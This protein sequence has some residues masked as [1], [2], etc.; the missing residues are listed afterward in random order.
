ME[1]PLTHLAACACVALALA[2]PSPARAAIYRYDPTQFPN[3]LP[4]QSPTPGTSPWT[5][6]ASPNPGQ[7]FRTISGNVLTIYNNFNPDSLR[8]YYYYNQDPTATGALGAALSSTTTYEMRTRVRILTPY[9]GSG[10]GSLPLYEPSIFDG[11]KLVSLGVSHH[12]TNNTTMFFFVQAGFPDA[13][14]TP[15]ETS[16][17]PVRPDGFYD[18]WLRK[19]G[20]TGGASD[21]VQVFVDGVLA[22][23]QAYNQFENT[24]YG[25]LR[26]LNFGQ[27]TSGG[28]SGTMQITGITF[29]LGE[30]AP[31]VRE[32]AGA[33]V[34]LLGLVGLVCRRRR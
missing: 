28:V 24:P 6:A 21:T 29:G 22:L 5:E 2:A 16:A 34:T 23:S 19:T 26:E 8:S 10:F 13:D 1:R 25:A 3:T 15:Y 14:T 9:G 20:T 11:T 32:P 30:A 17:P 18:V 4:H 31:A 12:N 7:D 33:S 27:D